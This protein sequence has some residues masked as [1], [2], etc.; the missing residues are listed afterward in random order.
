MLDMDRQRI[1]A[2]FLVMLM[3]LSPVAYAISV[4]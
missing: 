1:I 2:L 3:A 4:L